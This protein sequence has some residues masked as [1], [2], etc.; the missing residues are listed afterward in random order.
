MI[1]V[2]ATDGMALDGV[3]VFDAAEGIT[4]DV[5]KG[6]ESAELLQ[7]IPEYEGLIVRSATKVTAEII[8]AGEKLKAIGRAGVGVD[9]VDIPAASRKGIV[10]MNTPEANTIST[11]E[12]TLTMLFSLARRVP[13]ADASMKQGKWEKK[14][15]KGVE[16]FGKTIGIIGFGRIG[17]YVARVC[18]SAGM[19]VLA[20]DP[21][22]T[23]DRVRTE[24]VSPVTLDELFTQSDF[25]TVHTPVNNETRNLIRKETLAQ[26]KDGVRLINCARGGIINEDDLCDAIETGKVAGAALDV[27]P[28]EPNENRRLL[29]YPQ[30]ILTP[31]IAASTE[32]AQSK[33]GVEVAREMVAYLSE[34]TIL[35]AVNVS[36][37]GAEQ[38]QELM[39]FIDLGSRL[40]SIISQLAYGNLSEIHIS[41]EGCLGT[42]QIGP[43][44]NAIL[45]GALSYNIDGVNHVNAR[46]IA[47]ERGL[48]ISEVKTTHSMN[49]TNYIRIEAGRDREN[50]VS[51]G[52]TIFGEALQ[53]PRVVR[54]NGY[55][56][57]AVP[58]GCLFFVKHR[59]VPGVIG[60]IGTI[61]GNAGV[62]IN[63]MSC[64]RLKP[65]EFNVAVFSIDQEIPGDVLEVIRDTDWVI[66]AHQ[67][68]L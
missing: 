47:D 19:H 66:E 41:Y 67:V 4:I 55:H 3:A 10:V 35:N 40:G 6:I 45:C 9:N 54:I 26:M 37:V 39:P 46:L 65:G 43:I 59:D 34:G 32:E 53:H 42:R 28:K 33:V 21:M 38:M 11:A 20:Y 50:I 1:K 5:C 15:L 48:M 52:A 16:L 30:I 36:A 13:E 56:V 12:H 49:Y 64:D 18:T 27:F 24:N 23:E 44:T 7:K 31:H 22:V 8:R 29:E 68:R 14:K 63:R 61:L 58:E 57:D 25:I 51:L 17:R 2:L 60:R 62:N